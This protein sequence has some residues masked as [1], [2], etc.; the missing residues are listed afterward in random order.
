M[1]GIFGRHRCRDFD[2]AGAPAFRAEPGVMLAGAWRLV[3][4]GLPWSAELC[5]GREVN[6]DEDTQEAA[7]EDEAGVPGKR[8]GKEEAPAGDRSVQEAGEKVSRGL[9]I[10]SRHRPAKRTLS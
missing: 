3:S 7:H 5:S 8:S 6:D 1:D 9:R 2:Y 4:A 10:L